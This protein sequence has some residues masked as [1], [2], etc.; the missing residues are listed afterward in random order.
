MNAFRSGL[1]D[2]SY[3]VLVD[4]LCH[5]RDH[6]SSCLCNSYKSGVQGHIGIDLILLHALCPET[7]TASAHVPV[8]HIIYE[9]LESLCSL[10]D[11]VVHQVVI[12]CLDHGVHLG[13]QPLIHYRQ[14]I[15]F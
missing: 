4:L 8:T 3:Q 11:T 5:E 14:L 15:I 1:V 6:R 13:Q 12:Y 7:L 2:L 9:F 10:R